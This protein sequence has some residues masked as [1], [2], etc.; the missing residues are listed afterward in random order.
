MKAQWE[1]SKSHLEEEVNRVQEDLKLKYLQNQKLEEDIKDLQMNIATMKV[2]H[3]T[4]RL[5][6]GSNIIL[7]FFNS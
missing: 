6:F 2:N 7:M 5:D 1:R 4:D 3:V